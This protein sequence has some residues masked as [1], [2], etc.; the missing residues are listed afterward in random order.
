MPDRSKR[1]IQTKRDTLV[2]Q[3]WGLGERLTTSHRLETWNEAT[4]GGAIEEEEEEE[5]EPFKKGPNNNCWGTLS[6]VKRTHCNIQFLWN[7]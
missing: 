7:Y 1:M 4:N 3:V 2:L 5:E 6:E